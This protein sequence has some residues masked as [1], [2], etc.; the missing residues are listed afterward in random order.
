MAKEVASQVEEEASA[1]EVSNKDEVGE[2][3]QLAI[4]IAPISRWSVLRSHIPEYTIFSS[5]EQHFPATLLRILLARAGIEKNPGPH[6]CSVCEL[7]IHDRSIS[8]RCTNC[9]RWC[10]LR[11]CSGLNSH[12]EWQA[13]F[14]A[15]E[16][17]STRQ[18]YAPGQQNTHNLNV[19]HQMQHYSG[20]QMQTHNLDI[21]H[22]M[23]HYT[24]MQT[25]TRGQRTQ[26]R[27]HVHPETQERQQPSTTNRQVW[28]CCVCN[29]R[30]HG[31]AT[32]VQCS[33]CE[34]WCD[35]RNCSGLNRARDRLPNY[36]APCCTVPNNN[37]QPPTPTQQ[38]NPTY[39]QPQ[40]SVRAITQQP[41]Q[42]P[43]SHHR[44]NQ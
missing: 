11:Q 20:M 19:S 13:N 31:N 22:Q 16:P 23:Q 18:Q 21:S 41:H 24:A 3:Q 34:G 35:F 4:M 29:N 14:I 7:R 33:G 9:N 42:Q 25:Q 5:S 37:Q 12:R 36:L 32:S 40:T 30:I 6:T 8:V 44:Q 26:P 17:N 39:L 1:A 38:A 28:L 10:H 2:K 43:E 27:P 15:G